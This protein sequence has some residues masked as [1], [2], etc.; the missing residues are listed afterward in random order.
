VT[1]GQRRGGATTSRH[2]DSPRL[3]MFRKNSNNTRPPVAMPPTSTPIDLTKSSPPASKKQKTSHTPARKRPTQTKITSFAKTP[4]SNKKSTPGGTAKKV[5]KN[6][7]ILAFFKPISKDQKNKKPDGRSDSLFIADGSYELDLSEP[8]DEDSD[9]E[10]VWAKAREQV[11]QEDS[12]EV[13][14]Q[15]SALELASE[16]AQPMDEDEEEAPKSDDSRPST[17]K[18]NG[19]ARS[20]DSFASH[21]SATQLPQPTQKPK[22]DVPK[23]NAG[24]LKLN[25]GSSMLFGK[26]TQS[27]Q[28]VS[29][30]QATQDAPPSSPPSPKKPNETVGTSESKIKNDVKTEPAKVGKAIDFLKHGLLWA[31]GKNETT[32]DIES[33]MPQRNKRPAGEDDEIESTYVDVHGVAACMEK[34]EGTQDDDD[35]EGEGE[36][37]EEEEEGEEDEEEYPEDDEEGSQ[38][39][40]EESQATFGFDPVARAIEAG[41]LDSDSEVGSTMKSSNAYDDDFTSDKGPSCPICDAKLGG[42]SESD[43]NNHVNHCLDGTPIPLPKPKTTAV[44]TSTTTKVTTTFPT[45]LTSNPHGVPQIVTPANSKGKPSAFAKIMTANTEAQAWASTA[46]EQADQWGKRAVERTCP[47]YKILYGGPVAVDAFLYGAVPGVKA[48]FLSHFHSD[49]YRGLSRSWVHGPIY[50]SRVTA[51]L[52]RSRLRVDP[53]YVIELPWEEWT[54]VPNTGGVRV[55]GLDANHCPGS[56][57][58]LFEKQIRGKPNRILHCGDFRADKKHLDHPLLKNQ[59]IDTVYLDTTYLDPKYAF[60]CQTSVIE[61][62]AEMTISL[63][64]GKPLEPEPGGLSGYVTADKKKAAAPKGRLLIVV[65]TYSIGKERICTGI[66]HAIKSKIYATPQKLSTLRQIEDP[67]LEKLLTTK[68]NEAQ[69][70][71]THLGGISPDTLGTYLASHP[72]F[73]RIVAFSPSGWS[74]KPPGSRSSNPKVEDVLFSPSWRS[75]YNI[76]QMKSMRG[77]NEKVKMFAVPYSEHSSFRELSIFCCALQIGK[78]IP[79]VNVGSKKSRDKMNGWIEKWDQFRRKQGGWKSEEEGGEGVW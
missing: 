5:A 48:Y 36:D 55:Q 14:P 24:G 58:F 30:T 27:S 66:A 18:S 41:F 29:P 22:F 32:E 51:N 31:R 64:T 47:F 59:R 16:A 53:Q 63:N 72:N 50:C 3:A 75:V 25:L 28:A 8:E 79:T 77:S 69:V 62:C 44:S 12:T 10:I 4:S 9:I 6:A 65:G 71:L 1:H 7:S 61:A 49:H 34:D 43:K 76:A 68:P 46:K 56:M 37:Y 60:P 40:F 20:E 17:A 67:E 15:M 70:H 39:G 45:P 74:Y 13:A 2:P 33:T 19:T 57:L 78:V 54:E 73:D 52:V 21:V 26:P 42:L 38:M 35:E 23:F 11:Q